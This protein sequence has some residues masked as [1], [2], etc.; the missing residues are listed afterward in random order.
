LWPNDEGIHFVQRIDS[1]KSFPKSDS[2]RENWLRGLDLNQR[3]GSCRI[4]SRFDADL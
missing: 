3:S 1:S 4:M 2:R